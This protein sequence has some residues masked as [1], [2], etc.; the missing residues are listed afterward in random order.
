MSD[1]IK[2]KLSIPQSILR[3]ALAVGVILLLPL[4]GMQFS[5]EISWSTSDFITMGSVLL[6]FGL[7]YELVL[8]RVANKDRRF[9]AIILLAGLFFY[10][11]AELAVGIFT[12]WGN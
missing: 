7:A 6:V 1:I 11:W 4:I 10:L 2:N 8:K 9:V 12:N 3:V 5:S